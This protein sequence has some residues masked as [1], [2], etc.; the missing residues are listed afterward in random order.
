MTRADIEK[1]LERGQRALKQWKRTVLT[2]SEKKLLAQV[3]TTAEDAEMIIERNVPLLQTLKAHYPYNGNVGCPHC[4]G[5]TRCEDRMRLSQRP[6][7]CAWYLASLLKQCGDKT[8]DVPYPCCAATFGGW[9]HDDQNVIAYGSN[10][11]HVY[12]HDETDREAVVFIRGHI[13]W[14][15]R[16]LKAALKTKR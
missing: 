3:S 1:A 14:A 11:E 7:G 15:C 12:P 4:A 9:R 16:V 6:R 13:E 8:G 5:L 2:A 10:S